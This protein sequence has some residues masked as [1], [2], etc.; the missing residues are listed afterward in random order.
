LGNDTRIVRRLLGVGEGGV[1]VDRLGEPR[2]LGRALIAL[3]SP[4]RLIVLVGLTVV[5]PIRVALLRLVP[6]RLVGIDRLTLGS[7]A[8]L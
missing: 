6:P 7:P 5:G 2:R 4:V 8:V 1:V 3:V